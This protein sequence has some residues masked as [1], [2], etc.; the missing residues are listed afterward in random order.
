VN[1]DCCKSGVGNVEKDSRQGV[2]GEEDN[3]RGDDTSERGSNT[4][5]GLDGGT[6]ERTSRWETTQE[7]CQKV[8][9]TN[10]NKLLR[11][12]N[13]V[14]IDTTERFGNGDV[15]DKEDDD[16]GRNLAGKDLDH[17]CVDGRDTGVLESWSDVSPV[18]T[19]KVERAHL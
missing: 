19:C 18:F 16:R 12:I 15:F 10:S 2:D 3:H 6:G 1:D 17:R 8:G 4:G 5:L 9:H 13:L 7:R 11:W 14:S